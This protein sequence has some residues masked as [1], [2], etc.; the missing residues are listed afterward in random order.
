MLW[1][2]NEADILQ[3]L[4]ERAVGIGWVSWESECLNFTVFDYVE[5]V[6]L[7]G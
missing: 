4:K 6:H 3:S 1:K 2:K 7:C 5:R